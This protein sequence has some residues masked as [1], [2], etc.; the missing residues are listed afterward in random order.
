MVARILQ[1]DVPQSSRTQLYRRVRVSRS[2]SVRQQSI[3]KAATHLNSC[4]S[5]F[6]AS[7]AA[8]SLAE[9]SSQISNKIVQSSEPVAVRKPMSQVS[10]LVSNRTTHTHQSSLSTPFA[11]P[12]HVRSLSRFRKGRLDSGGL[13]GCRAGLLHMLRVG[14]RLEAKRESPVAVGQNGGHPDLPERRCEAT[15]RM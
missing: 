15:F 13:S 14:R 1:H 3:F 4:L 7:F 5:A 8:V 11:P 6:A 12:S 9:A 10:D 2:Q